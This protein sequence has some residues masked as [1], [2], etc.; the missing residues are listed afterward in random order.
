MPDDLDA[1]D[2]FLGNRVVFVGNRSGTCVR[3][4]PAY[5]FPEETKRSLVFESASSLLESAR[6][7]RAR[8]Q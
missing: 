5:L 6:R 1:L 8:A 3:P 2:K 4:L 7:A